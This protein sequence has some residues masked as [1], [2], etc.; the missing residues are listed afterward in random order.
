MAVELVG[1]QSSATF[2]GSEG[3][4]I[5][6]GTLVGR[7]VSDSLQYQLQNVTR[8][9]DT[10]PRYTAILLG[11][12][13]AM[14]FSQ[15]SDTPVI[16][17]GTAATLVVYD[18]TAQSKSMTMSAVVAS[19]SRTRDTTDQKSHQRVRMVFQVSAGSGTSVVTAA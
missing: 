16:P 14:E 8:F 11:G 6:S 18:D 15:T 5:T 1:R 4:R 3:S 12:S 19:I 10:G 9:R 2:S 7:V 17:S 13:I